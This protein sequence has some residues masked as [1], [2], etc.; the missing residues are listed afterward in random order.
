MAAPPDADVVSKALALA[1][2]RDRTPEDTAFLRRFFADH[3]EP[4]DEDPAA[5]AARLSTAE[6]FGLYRHLRAD[7][8]IAPAVTYA[9]LPADPP[10]PVAAPGDH[11]ARAVRVLSERA[12]AAS[13]HGDFVDLDEDYTSAVRQE[14]PVPQVVQAD[15]SPA[16]E[17]PPAAPRRGLT[18]AAKKPVSR[19]LLRRVSDSMSGPKLAV[20]LV[21]AAVAI[22]GGSYGTMY[23][24][25]WQAHR[26][27]EPV[28]QMQQ[29]TGKS[30]DG[31]SG[32]PSGAP[33]ENKA[34]SA[35]PTS[36]PGGKS[37]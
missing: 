21:G 6:L 13:S 25:N 31:I 9:L 37:R 2:Q 14:V 4:R 7:S 26:S 34:R 16:A 22:A 35:S 33:L 5:H 29:R 19:G 32:D 27:A 18:T 17:A 12:P 30:A 11:E 10:V 20:S 8:D 28:Q 15:E 1:D 23:F 36:A 3:L 24:I